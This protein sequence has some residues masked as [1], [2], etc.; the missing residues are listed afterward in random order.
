MTI[1]AV[2]LPSFSAGATLNQGDLFTI[3][4]SKFDIWPDEIVLGYN[5]T[6]VKSENSLNATMELVE[7]KPSSLVFRVRET[8]TYPAA[9]AWS[10]FGTP[11]RAPRMLLDYDLR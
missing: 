3:T 9:H 4:G 6:Y 1:D 5:E 8:R 11:S 2:T 10:F 7:K